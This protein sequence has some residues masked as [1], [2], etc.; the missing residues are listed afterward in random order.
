MHARSQLLL[1]HLEGRSHAVT[2]GLASQL[3]RAMPG[4]P[5][6]MLP[7]L[8]CRLALSSYAGSEDT[9]EERANATESGYR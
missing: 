6:D 4:E 9:N 3:K 5:A 2:L 7:S 1:D 8:P